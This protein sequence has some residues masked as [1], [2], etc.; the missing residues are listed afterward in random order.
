MP[1]QF[2]LSVDKPCL[3]KW[4]DFTPTSTGGFCRSCS[5][6][7][8]DFT[9]MSDAE[10]IEYFKSKP[11]NTC[12][13]FSPEQLRTYSQITI[14]TTNQGFK[15]IRTGLLGLLTLLVSK[16]G[17]AS[18]ASVKPRTEV[19]QFQTHY[20]NEGISVSSG[21]FIQGIVTDE[22]GEP[23][24]GVNVVVKETTIRTV[25]DID[26]KFKFSSEL[27][28]GDVLLFY[29]IGYEAREYVISQKAPA[30]IEVQMVMDVQV[31]GEVVVGGAYIAEPTG[32]AGLWHKIK[33][34]F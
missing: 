18:I 23:L 20:N 16:P 9:K 24:P 4:D 17:N 10:I 13:R 30:V 28:A 19:A 14:T 27:M 15:W 5:K 25:T 21:H 33:N 2:S 31:L 7:V 12:G 26:G 1:R 22:Y 3:E 32:L 8:I 29:F 11:A 6:N 34:L